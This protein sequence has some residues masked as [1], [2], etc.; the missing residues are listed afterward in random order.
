MGT[1]VFFAD[2]YSS[3]QKG[4]VEHVNK[5]V[6]QYFPKRTDFND[7]TILVL[8]IP[9][10]LHL[11]FDPAYRFALNDVLNV[12]YFSFPLYCE[13]FPLKVNTKM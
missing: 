9:I 11:L 3:W 8:N 12:I 2:P 13:W 10:F 7:I 6:R 4:A 1:P 5:L